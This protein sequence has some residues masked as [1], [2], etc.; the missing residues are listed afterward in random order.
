MSIKNIELLALAPESLQVLEHRAALHSRYSAIDFKVLEVKE[1]LRG[2]VVI[3]IRQGKS[4]TANYFD[5]KRLAEIVH[6]TFDDLF[7]PGTQIQCRP[8]PYR[9]SPPDV[10]DAA[11]LQ[12]HR[13]QTPIKTI[14][15]DLGIDPNNVSS[16][17]SGNKPLSGVMRAA[18]YWYFQTQKK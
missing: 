13:G 7:P 14:A 17:F 12:Q 15:H 3:R 6:E 16:Y 8:L 2:V 5:A 4:H 9:P 18:F 11:W 1:S 10:V